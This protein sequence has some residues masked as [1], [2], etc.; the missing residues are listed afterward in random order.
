MAQ[1]KRTVS[2]KETVLLDY[3]NLWIPSVLFTACQNR[4]WLVLLATVTELALVAAT[5]FSTSLIS[6]TP[7]DIV[8]PKP[9][10]FQS[11]FKNDASL[12]PDAA[13]G[14]FLT[15]LGFVDGN[16][17][18]PDGTSSS[19]AYQRF[20]YDMD[21]G[22]D[23]EI[24]AVVDGISVD[25]QCQ[26]AEMSGWQNT[27]ERE[28]AHI[29]I[30]I[31]TPDCELDF[32]VESSSVVWSPLDMVARYWTGYCGNRTWQPESFRI[33]VAFLELDNDYSP[34]LPSSAT[35]TRQVGNRTVQQSTQLICT[36]SYTVVKLD[37]LSR[38]GTV[39]NLTVVETTPPRMLENVS[40]GDMIG[41]MGR[42]GSMPARLPDWA[43]YP[44][45]CGH[46][47]TLLA[48]YCA[49]G[50]SIDLD[51]RLV[52]ALILYYP[53]PQPAP[54]SPDLFN[55]DLLGSI[56]TKFFH[57]YIIQLVD[58]AL[59]EP[60]AWTTMG[61]SRALSD[62]L[63]FQ[64]LGTHLMTA[65]LAV[66][67]T[68]AA[69]MIMITPRSGMLPRAP[70]TIVGVAVNLAERGEILRRLSSTGATGATDVRKRVKDK[71]G[72]NRAKIPSSRS[73]ELWSWPPLFEDH[74]LGPG[75]TAK[76]PVEIMTVMRSGVIFAILSLIALLEVSLRKSQHSNG[77]AEIAP[78]DTIFNYVWSFGP[79]IVSQAL[80]DYH[81]SVDFVARTRQPLKNMSKQHGA[82]YASTVGL[83]LVDRSLP[84]SVIAAI[85][86]K[87]FAPLCTTAAGLLAA[88]LTVISASLFGTKSTQL[89]SNN[90]LRQLDSFTRH[91][92]TPYN[93]N[94]WG[95]IAGPLILTKNMSY[96]AFTYEDLVLP[97]LTLEQPFAGNGTL[98]TSPS[99]STFFNV[100]A[101]VAA[102]RA[103]L[104]CQFYD[105]SMVRPYIPTGMSLVEVTIGGVDHNSSCWVSSANF[106]KGLGGTSELTV[107]LAAI[108]GRPST[109]DMDATTM[110]EGCA[111][112]YIF[113]WGTVSTA[114]PQRTS[115]VAYGC[116]E[117]IEAVEADVHLLG[118]DL[119]ID[120][121]IP[122]VVGNDTA[123]TTPIRP[124]RTISRSV[125]G[126]AEE[127]IYMGSL[128]NIVP[129]GP[130]T[131]DQFFRFMTAP[132]SR[133]STPLAVVAD[134]TQKDRVAD[135]IRRQHGIIRAQGLSAD[136]RR[137]FES[138]DT[139]KLDLN[140]PNFV[141]NG[142]EWAAA[143]A[144]PALI[145]ATV[146]DPQ[147]RTRLTQDAG[148]TRILQ[149]FLAGILLFSV[150]GWALLSAESWVADGEDK[151]AR[152]LAVWGR[153]PTCIASV[154]ALLAESNVFDFLSCDLAVPGESDE[155]VFEGCRF[156]L[157]WVEVEGHS[158]GAQP[159]SLVVD[160]KSQ[161]VVDERGVVSEEDGV[162]AGDAIGKTKGERS[163][164]V[165]TLIV[166]GARHDKFGCEISESDCASIHWY[167]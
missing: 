139:V 115:M 56:T 53:L 77:L 110:G 26:T 69:V 47:G 102:L 116:N 150:A 43:R 13:T 83:E 80:S 90:Q 35:I 66:A 135:A 118:P 63:L 121:S 15:M 158:P 109:L 96:S 145:N 73:K 40:M 142:T 1:S 136:Y 55:A 46:K 98:G 132:E 34:Y 156:K 103:R 108:G 151:K 105:A 152:D 19:F 36:P 117:T 58:E 131:V 70:N 163:N 87:S 25:V 3:F 165:F 12:F 76:P 84:S 160:A 28:Q 130:P 141:Y 122:P 10:V 8:K 124:H 164:R 93:C 123:R 32:S 106:D 91:L 159:G 51:Q 167:I 20:S 107:G 85:K 5:V 24:R 59:T 88:S 162:M 148:S 16:L 45:V 68:L 99:S 37:T 97:R 2:A 44:D 154:M 21:A 33:G 11:T 64:P 54:S 41:F 75:S 30:T 144:G 82:S 95:Y 79:A 104:E 72:M 114:S 52:L 7:V 111:A 129:A 31:N 4:D 23:A 138:L 127:D 65:S 81:S 9:V 128:P 17:P 71:K 60:T 57:Q 146:T 48:D 27:P 49:K 89:S 29:D 143:P 137:P 149:G 155:K 50:T 18:F 6:L 78:G 39:Q 134:P 153:S 86:T 22:P 133:F 38:A 140:S 147:G 62:R 112:D 94:D 157:G 14:A 67:V 119:R 113:A 92:E 101:K 161:A 100:T 42:Q 125:Q 61:T 126:H 74:R 166:V 120:T